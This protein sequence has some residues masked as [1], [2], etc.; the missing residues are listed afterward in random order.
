MIYVLRV[1]TPW[2]CHKPP[3]YSAALY[4]ACKCGTQSVSQLCSCSMSYG[5]CD[6][7]IV[8]CSET[9]NICWHRDSMGGLAWKAIAINI[10]QI[11]TKLARTHYLLKMNQ[12]RK[13][14]TVYEKKN[15]A[16]IKFLFYRGLQDTPDIWKGW[17]V[18]D[19]SEESYKGFSSQL[20]HEN[21]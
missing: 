1:A 13:I 9:S 3:L 19:T 2:Q 10:L 4:P 21:G 12:R 11:Y 14:Q 17:A 15:G 5:R 16:S 18:G 6:T 20:K 8:R 7:H